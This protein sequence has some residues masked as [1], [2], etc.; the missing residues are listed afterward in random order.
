MK[1]HKYAVLICTSISIIAILGIISGIIINKPLITAS[2]ILPAVIYELYITKGIFAK[3]ISL[4]LLIVLLAEIYAIITT[5][6][7]DLSAMTGG[8]FTSLIN[9]SLIGPVIII[10]LTIY[11]LR[12]TNGIYNKWLSIIILLSSI[13]LFYLIF[14][15]IIPDTPKI[16]DALESIENTIQI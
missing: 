8:L 4:L 9:A 11:L 10:I 5:I 12:R 6:S 15:V 13:V 14:G 1:E 2:I 3:A 7:V 16:P